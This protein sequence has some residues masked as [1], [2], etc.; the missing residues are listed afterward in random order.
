MN[1]EIA[2]SRRELLEPCDPFTFKKIF[3]IL[4]AFVFCLHICLCESVRF[5]RGGDRG[6]CEL[7][8]GCWELNLG[9]LEE[10]PVLLTAESSVQFTPLN[11]F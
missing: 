6:T 10:Q 1:C 5:P 4:C 7:P 3:I 8:H 11:I 2:L 9:P